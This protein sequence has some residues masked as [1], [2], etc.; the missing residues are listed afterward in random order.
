MLIGS[1]NAVISA[2][3]TSQEPAD[4]T[5][6][7][8]MSVSLRI[9]YNFTPTA[10]TTDNETAILYYK[11]NNSETDITAFYN[12]SS[13]IGYEFDE[14]GINLTAILYNY[15]L[16]DN[17]VYPQTENLQDSVFRLYALD[18][19]LCIL[20]IASRKISSSLR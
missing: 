7:N 8:I 20:N 2:N 10:V 5:S 13:D 18:S 17:E 12:G 6:I 19:K 15:T 3:L 9:Q 1:L 11:S 14:Y 4:L 16:E